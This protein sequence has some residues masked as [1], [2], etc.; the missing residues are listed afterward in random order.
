MEFSIN[1]GDT[2]RTLDSRNGIPRN[3]WTAEEFAEYMTR[4]QT[5]FPEIKFQCG[6]EFDHKRT[7]GG[8]FFL[9]MKVRPNA[10]MRAFIVKKGAGA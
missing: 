1:E 4:M 3:T 2:V 8:D 10:R 7:T 5:T 6:T 9:T